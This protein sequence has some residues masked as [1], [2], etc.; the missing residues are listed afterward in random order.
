MRREPKSSVGQGCLVVG[1]SMCV[2]AGTLQLLDWGSWRR[3]ALVPE[4]WW[5]VRG[6]G[7]G[8]GGG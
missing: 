4:L 3:G 1:R 5:P 6:W 2:P 7:G 8:A